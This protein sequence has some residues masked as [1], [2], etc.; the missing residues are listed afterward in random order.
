VDRIYADVNSVT[1]LEKGSIQ[2][3]RKYTHNILIL[4]RL[5]KFDF[6]FVNGTIRQSRLSG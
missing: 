1:E 6:N 2:Q 4:G 5:P 3:I